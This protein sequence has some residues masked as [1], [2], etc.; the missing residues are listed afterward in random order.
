MAQIVTLKTD[1]R[2]SAVVYLCTTPDL[3]PVMGG[4]ALARF[5]GNNPPV[6]GA[7]YVVGVDD[8]P[9]FRVFATNRGV[10]VS[11][12]REPPRARPPWAERPL[13]ECRE[14]GQPRARYAN[15]ASCPQCGE[16]WADA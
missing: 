2:D 15:P 12:T 1:P 5:V 14:C 9:R 13:P 8:L 10:H 4:F 6:T 11:D 7:S 3:A 16:P